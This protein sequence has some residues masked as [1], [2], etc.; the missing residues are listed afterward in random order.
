MVLNAE[1]GG[2]AVPHAF[3]GAI[4]EIDVSDLHI[5]R[6]AGGIDRETMILTGDTNLAT[7]QIFNRLIAAAMAKFEFEGLSTIG[8]T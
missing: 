6:E 2:F 7:A 3:D 1:N 5:G 4:I 8:V